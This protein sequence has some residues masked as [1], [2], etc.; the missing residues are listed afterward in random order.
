MDYSKNLRDLMAGIYTKEELE[1]IRTAYISVSGVGGSVGSYLIDILVRKG[2]E[3]FILSDPEKYE[4]RNVSRQ[5]FAN[6]TTLNKSKLEMVIEHLLKINPNINYRTYHKIDLENAEN[7]VKD[8]TVCSY[9]AEGFSPWVL[10]N[11]MCSKYRV[12]FVNV[13]RKKG[14]SRSTLAVVTFDYRLAKNIFDI[15]KIDFFSF[16][17]SYNTTKKVIKMFESGNINQKILDEADK[18]HNTFKKKQRFKNLGEL[19]PEVGSIRNRFPEDYFKR[20]TDPEMCLIT[21]ALAARTITDFVIG[22]VTK[23]SEL[24]IFSREKIK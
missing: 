1:K 3:N 16:G 5:L 17:I 10:T 14:G 13:A 24:D 6:L 20:Y 19:Y 8:A 9:Q 11:Y 2:F 22:R 18:I 21:G 4:I 15:K 23:I 7:I 12:P